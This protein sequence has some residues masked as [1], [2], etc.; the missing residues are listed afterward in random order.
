[1]RRLY[2]VT[3]YNY[4]IY[5]S[6]LSFHDLVCCFKCCPL[7]HKHCGPLNDHKYPI[8]IFSFINS[9]SICLHV[10]NPTG[11][12]SWLEWNT[13]SAKRKIKHLFWVVMIYHSC[14]QHQALILTTLDQLHELIIMIVPLFIIMNY[15]ELIMLVF[16]CPN[17]DSWNY[18]L[19]NVSLYIINKFKKSL[20][21]IVSNEFINKNITSSQSLAPLQEYIGSP[22]LFFVM[23][24]TEP[25]RACLCNA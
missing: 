12:L 22:L 2:Y 11:V 17:K 16:N 19:K 6:S 10:I 25:I 1:M 13:I 23:G 7:K 8:N 9:G 4:T 18:V 5:T 14:H 21:L 3:L 15:N 24:T 20:I